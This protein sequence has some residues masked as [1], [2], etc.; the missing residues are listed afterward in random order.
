MEEKALLA[1]S[2]EET[3]PLLPCQQPGSR[4][5]LRRDYCP[6][7]PAR[8]VLAM[9]I[10]LGFAVV[11]GLRVNLSVAI[12]QMDNDTATVYNGSAEVLNPMDH[13]KT[14]LQVMSL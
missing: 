12:V 9:M 10:N 4:S 8:Y 1:V 3:T 14:S 7:I 6:C 11:Y 5:C 2:D 13:H